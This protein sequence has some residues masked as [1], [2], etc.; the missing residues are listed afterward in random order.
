MNNKEKIQT[1]ST[2]DCLNSLPCGSKINN[3]SLLFLWL[4]FNF[5]F[6]DMGRLVITLCFQLIYLNIWEYFL[7]KMLLKLMVLF[8]YSL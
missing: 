2:T 6:S 4:C 1:K 7:L 5:Y 3:D 8:L